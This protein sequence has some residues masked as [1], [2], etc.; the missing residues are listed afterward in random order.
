MNFLEHLAQEVEQTGHTI[1]RGDSYFIVVPINLKIE[2]EIGER[3]EHEN[4]GERTVL[5]TISIKATHDELFPDGIW[6]CLAGMG[7][8]DDD[9]FSYAAQVWT[10]GVFPPIHEILVPIETVS[11]GVQRINIVA[12]NEDSGEEFSWKLYLGALQVAGDVDERE[13]FTDEEIL[14]KKMFDALNPELIE[15]RLIWIK[16]YIAKMP[17]GSIRGDC[18]LNNHDWLEG[19]SALYWFAEEWEEVKYL[20]Y[21]KQFMIIKPCDWSEIENAEELKQALLPQKKPNFFSKWFKK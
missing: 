1:Q 7:E 18:W 4:D 13:V 10:A 9:A 5:I 15:K 3:K 21:I 11:L 20:T 8:D 16:T 2:A 12:R 17:D 6:D 19:L 14:V